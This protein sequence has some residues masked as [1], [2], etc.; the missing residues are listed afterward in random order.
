MGNPLRTLPRMALR[1]GLR[2]VISRLRRRDIESQTFATRACGG[3][4]RAL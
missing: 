2:P 1:R 3:A 4:R